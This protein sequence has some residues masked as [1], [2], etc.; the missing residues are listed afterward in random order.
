MLHLE[1]YAHSCF[2]LHA[3]QVKVLFDPYSPEIGY[4]LPPR[5]AD[6]VLVSHE[7]FDHNNVAGV[8]GRCTVVR[9]CARRSVGSGT[10]HGVLGDHGST[11]GKVT[12]F[13]LHIGDLR[14]CHLS[15]LGQGL[16]T[17]QLSEIG[18]PDVLMVPV[19]GG[20]FTLDATA[21][22]A[23][24]KQLKPRVILPMHYRTPFL[25][26]EHFPLLQGVEPFLQQARAEYGYER[27]NDGVLRWDTLPS[28][29]T[30]VHMPHLY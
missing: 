29:P 9:G 17:E 16:N 8:A 5:G 26:K 7:H 22:L 14:V 2:L 30:V 4:K 12:M 27:L 18:S 15:D 13:C 3:G 20:N 19:G 28:K 25:N 11:G 6:Y 24:I 23:V 1:Y 10:V 21:A